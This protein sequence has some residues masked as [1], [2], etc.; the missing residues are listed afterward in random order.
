MI[1]LT[2]PCNKCII[3]TKEV[4]LMKLDLPFETELQEFK[5]SLL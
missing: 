1:L 5:T 3:K 2:K 4:I